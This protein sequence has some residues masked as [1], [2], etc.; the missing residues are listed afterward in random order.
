MDAPEPAPAPAPAPAPTTAPIAAPIA[1]IVLSAGRSSRMGAFKPLMRFG[2]R[3]VLGRVVDTLRRGGVSSIVVVYGHNAPLMAAAVA[4]L[5]VTGVE[6]AAYDRGMLSSVQ[7]GIAALP[8]G[9]AGCLIL[10]VDMPLLRPTTVARVLR[11][12]G[13]S[14]TV[15]ALPT[16]AGQ[17]GHPPFIGRALF[18][19]ILEAG[20]APGGL[21]AILDRHAGQTVE[22]PVFD[23]GC[24]RDMDYPHEHRAL[25]AALTH[26][27]SPDDAECAAML[28]AAATPEPARRHGHAVATLADALARRLAV[29]G[30]R[31]DHDRLH[32]AA[33]LHD[34]AKGRPHHAEAGAALVAGFGFPEVGA[35][36]AEHMELPPGHGRLDDSGLDESALLFLADKLVNGERRVSLEDRFAPARRR[37]A[38]DADALAGV[39]R[40]RAK[41]E[42]VLRAVTNRIGTAPALWEVRP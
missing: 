23:S 35:I 16:F 37:F 40:R 6:N 30:I 14:G 5:G 26:H 3:S 18:S 10:P 39:A 13:T 1:A 29:T 19:E 11:A 38:G 15:L 7:A 28:A 34:I 21:R 22:V 8:D 2:D 32:A 9:T 27:A 12:A 42:A 4:E 31:L 36:I 17:R 33:L 24:L 41:A 25:V 20:D